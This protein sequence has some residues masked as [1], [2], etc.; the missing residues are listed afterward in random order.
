LIVLSRGFDPHQDWQAMPV[1]LLRF[2]S[3]SQQSIAETSSHTIELDQPQA[4]LAAIVK[5]AM[6][7]R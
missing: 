5:M 7:R 4:G 1:E 3:D 2:S 6:Q